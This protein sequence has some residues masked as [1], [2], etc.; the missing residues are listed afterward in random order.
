MYDLRWLLKRH[1]GSRG[2][3]IGTL[4][5]YRNLP[6]AEK[7]EIDDQLHRNH[8]QDRKIEAAMTLLEL[9]GQTRD[10]SAAGLELMR[11][12]YKAKLILDAGQEKQQREEEKRL[13]EG[14]ETRTKEEK[15]RAL[16]EETQKIPAAT[17]H[18]FALVQFR[19]QHPRALAA[20]RSSSRGDDA[21]LEGGLKVV[22]E[23]ELRGA[24]GQRV[25][26]GV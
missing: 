23:G 11:L 16:I 8:E 15:W 5:Q 2:E 7:K 24:G 13:Q 20:L 4:L 19:R 21:D 18:F 25:E 12:Q 10:D 17:Q 26:L 9:S 3:M 22:D 1:N 6:A 14:H